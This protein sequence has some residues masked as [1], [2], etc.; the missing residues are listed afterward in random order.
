[1]FQID[2]RGGRGA[3]YQ[4]LKDEVIRLTGMGVLSPDDQLPG[5]RSLAREL[6]INP[7]TVAKAYSQLEADGITYSV[8]GRGSF[9]R[10]DAVQLREVR[11]KTL[12]DFKETVSRA[13]SLGLSAGELHGAVDAVFGLAGPPPAGTGNRENGGKT[14]RER[15]KEDDP[16]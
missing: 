12:L 5:V 13:R 11:R 3:I 1:M 15:V 10:G 4:Q 9:I 14:E 2:L 16:V 8:P 7:N 6:G